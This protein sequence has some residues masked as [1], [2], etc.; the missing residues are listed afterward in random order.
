MNFDIRKISAQYLTVNVT[1]DNVSMDLGTFDKDQARNL[2]T[3]LA[4]TAEELLNDLDGL[5]D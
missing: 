3:E 2:Y 1:A 4:E 5:K